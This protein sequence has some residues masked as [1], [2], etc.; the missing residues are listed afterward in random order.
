MTGVAALAIVG[1]VVV[2]LVR[3]SEEAIVTLF[4]LAG[5]AGFGAF[6]AEDAS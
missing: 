5:G 1:L 2:A 4:L 6:F 3:P